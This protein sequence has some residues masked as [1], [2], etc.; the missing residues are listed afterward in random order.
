MNNKFDIIVIGGGPNGLTSAAYLAKAGLKVLVMDRNQE[1]GGGLATEMVTFP[2]FLTNTHAV[3]HMMVDYAPIFKDLELEPRYNIKFAYPELQFALP[4][5]DGRS[6]CMY[7]DVEKTCKSFAQFSKKDADS[8]R[9]VAHKGQEFMDAF[10]GPL[11]YMPAM[12]ALEQLPIFAKSEIGRE[13]NEW[14]EK[15]PQEIVEG[16]FENDHIRTLLYYACCHWGVDWDCPHMGF[17]TMINFN[18]S[19]AYRLAIGGT[20]R[21]ASALQKVVLENGGH[22]RGAQ[23]IKRIIVDKGTAKGVE[24]DDGEII[25]AS[26]GVLSTIDL[27]TTFNK[28]VGAKNLDKD[29]VEGIGMWHW[30][31]WSL[32]QIHMALKQPPVFKAAE[33]NPD[34]NK[35]LCYLIGYESSQE[36]KDQWSKIDRGERQIPGFIS[37]FPSVFDPGQAPEGKAT[38][39]ISQMA[40][41][42]LK[43]GAAKWENF[44]FKEQLINERVD[45]LSQYAPNV[46][47]DNLIWGYAVTP[48][49]TERRFPDMVKGSYKQGKYMTV[50]MGFNRPNAECSNKRTPINGLWL[51][52]ANTYPGGM[53]LYGPGY[54]AANAIAEDLNVKKWWSEPD[55]VQAA[56]AKGV[57]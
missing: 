51:G 57:I 12:G 27:D 39:L 53:A 43:E 10:L 52:G 56:K 3:Y 47:R 32:L 22:L 55:C 36:L 4:L 45:L 7:S 9:I 17:M 37:S 38:G 30:E 18:R 25:E 21:I 5:K 41:Y 24:L 8:Y 28:Y 19:T 33:K 1:L 44:K 16:N 50:Q 35:A 34:L 40:P 11:T 2:G 26:K 54:L 48:L 6:V 23:W 42:D 13:F 15:S 31:R 46:N 14:S 20:H 49:G 29:F